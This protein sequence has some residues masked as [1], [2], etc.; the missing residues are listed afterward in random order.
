MAVLS[1]PEQIDRLRLATLRAMLRLEI[2]GMKRGRSPTAYS[3]LKRDL[4]LTGS[5]ES[6]LTRVNAILNG[7]HQ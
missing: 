4:G 5:R 1:T 6:V 7:D 3:I 2:L